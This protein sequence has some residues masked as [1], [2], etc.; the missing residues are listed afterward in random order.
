[1]EAI[2]GRV[3]GEAAGFVTWF[4]E[5]RIFSGRRAMRM[6]YLYVRPAFRTRPLAMLMLMYALQ[7]A[8]RRGYRYV[9]GQVLDWNAPAR[10]MYQALKARELDTRIFS[11]DLASL[12]IAKYARASH[13]VGEPS[14]APSFTPSLTPS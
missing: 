8:K 12:D 14:P 4:E 5:Y 11:L 2:V 9:E 6:D 3:N 10:R 7:V 1:M 13:P